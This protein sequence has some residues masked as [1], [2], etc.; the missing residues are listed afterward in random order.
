MKKLSFFII[1]CFTCTFIHS[2]TADYYI[3]S[4]FAKYDIKD[5]TGAIADFNKVIE[6]DTA[7]ILAYCC[8]GNAKARLSDY[9][10]AILDFSK[11][12]E[13]DPNCAS[14]YCASAYC[15]RSSAKCGLSDYTGAISDCNKIIKL[16][17]K[18][19]LAYFNRG[20][21]KHLQGDEEGAC[22]DWSKAG[23]LGD[24]KAYDYIKQYCNK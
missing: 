5:Y 10:G 19:N 6:L 16:Y 7:N 4:G 1:L 11:A 13:L 3:K 15:G 2:Q 18:N 22:L 24:N 21:A 9:R 23:E 14:E 8:R 12:I 17:P 20:N